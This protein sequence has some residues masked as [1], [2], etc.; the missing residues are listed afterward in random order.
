[1]YQFT[2]GTRKREI[3]EEGAEGGEGRVKKSLEV[4]G[5]A[6]QRFTA[7]VTL[8]PPNPN[9]LLRAISTR[10]STL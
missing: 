6:S 8:W 10:R 4:A 9:E 3:V 7:S 1:M 5:Y 2:P